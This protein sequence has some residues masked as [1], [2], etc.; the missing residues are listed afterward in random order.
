MSDKIKE[1]PSS[2]WSVNGEADPHKSKYDCE[3][4]DLTLGDLTDDQL[5]ND[6]FMYGDNNPTMQ[7]IISGTA[8]MPVIYLTAG[9]ERIRWLSRQNDKNLSHVAELKNALKAAFFEAYSLGYYDGLSD[10]QDYTSRCKNDD[11][12]SAWKSSDAIELLERLA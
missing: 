7:E 1:T 3:R 12:D 2:N 6:V 9:K 5:A 4:H 10:G 11:V 8:K